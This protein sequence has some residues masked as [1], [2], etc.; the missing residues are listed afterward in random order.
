M[1]DWHDSFYNSVAKK[2]ETKDKEV[3]DPLMPTPRNYKRMATSI[4]RDLKSTVERIRDN[5][6]FN[7]NA[8]D[9]MFTRAKELFEELRA[10]LID[11]DKNTPEADLKFLSK[12][13]FALLD[14]LDHMESL[15]FLDKME[16]K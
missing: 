3:D 8:P 5:S 2:Y 1:I 12:A 4:F 14:K 13:R 6:G 11:N 7:T 10:R 15:E 16:V 9:S